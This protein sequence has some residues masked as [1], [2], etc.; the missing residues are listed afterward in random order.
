MEGE[1]SGGGLAHF[2]HILDHDAEPLGFVV[3]DADIV[4]HMLRQVLLLTEQLGIADDRGEGSL[5]IVGDVGDELYFHPLA[6]HPLLQG[7]THPLMDTI[8]VLRCL[9]EIGVRRQFQRSGQVSA[10]DGG[11]PGSE[12]AELPE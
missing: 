9:P 3:E 8:E 12:G 7:G 6:L 5:E 1:L 10:P 4:L 2:E 11:K